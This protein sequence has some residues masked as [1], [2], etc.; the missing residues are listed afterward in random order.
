MGAWSKLSLDCRWI[1]LEEPGVV[2]DWRT[3][4]AVAIV[5]PEQRSVL[6]IKIH[7][8]FSRQQLHARNRQGQIVS[9]VH[10]DLERAGT[11][12]SNRRIHVLRD[13][14]GTGAI[15]PHARDLARGSVVIVARIREDD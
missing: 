10:G 2:V 8:A 13:D 6:R 3:K 4:F 15:H 1:S 5:K 14:R 9:V 7:A 11:P 12:L